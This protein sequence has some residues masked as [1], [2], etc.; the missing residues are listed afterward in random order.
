MYDVIKNYKKAPKELIEK[1]SKIEE[2]ASI[3]EITKQNALPGDVK[4]IWPGMRMCGPAFVVHTRPGDNLMVHKAL[5]M[6]QP[7]DILVIC[8]DGY[9][10]AGGMFGGMMA[11]SAKSKGCAGV[12]TDGA[13]R[14]T[15]LIKDLGLPVFSR[16]VNVLYATKATKGTINHPV[17][18]SGVDINP[19]DIIFGDNDAVVVVPREEAEAIYKETMIREDKEAGLLKR[20]LAGEGTTFDLAGFDKM[21]EKLGLSEEA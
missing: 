5:D 6:L 8:S 19:G 17:V 4:P 15:M 9:N 3:Y 12:L 18:F 10:G 1:Y 21:Y 11:A 2:S 13:V 16:G 14:D 7:G 20:I